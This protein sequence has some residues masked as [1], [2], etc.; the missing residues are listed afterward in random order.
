MTPSIRGFFY[1][2]K[3]AVP[4]HSFLWACVGKLQQLEVLNFS[5]I[6]MI[7]NI[8]ALTFAFIKIYLYNLYIL[9]GF[10][11]IQ[12][13]NKYMMLDEM[14]DSECCNKEGMNLMVHLDRWFINKKNHSL[15]CRRFG[16]LY[17]P[18]LS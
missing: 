6:L 12:K 3:E 10:Y 7:Y 11:I 18:L 15:S 16:H 17:V 14:D 8:F 1:H 4:S 2:K 13:H 9:I 5:Y